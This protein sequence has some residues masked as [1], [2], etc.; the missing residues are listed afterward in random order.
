LEKL[1]YNRL[2]SFINYHGILDDNQFGF[3]KNKSTSLAVANVLSSLITKSKL[4]KKVALVLLDHKKA[5]D[6]INHDLLLMKV[7]HYGIRWLPVIM[8]IQLFK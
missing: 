1:Y 3:R 2:P 7:K 8:V 4:I 5:F 6:F